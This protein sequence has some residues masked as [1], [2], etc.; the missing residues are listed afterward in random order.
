MSHPLS[1]SHPSRLA[2]LLLAVIASSAALS[3]ATSGTGSLS[4]RVSYAASGEY[5]EL[6]RV[7]LE[8]TGR[9]TFT[10]SSGSYTFP[11]IPAGGVRVRVFYTG[12]PGES[13]A[14]TVK[15]GET[16]LRDFALAGEPRARWTARR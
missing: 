15:A 14:I 4:G 7:T 6:A 11:E 8:G 10:D 5:L 9:E 12:L 2:R 3:G 1:A 13:A 16:T